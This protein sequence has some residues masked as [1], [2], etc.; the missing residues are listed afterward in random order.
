MQR[1]SSVVAPD[2]HEVDQEPTTTIYDND[3]H[4][5][6]VE[7]EVDK[8]GWNGKDA[9]EAADESEA[10]CDDKD[11]I[12]VVPSLAGLPLAG[13][14][15][16]HKASQ[17]IG[18]QVETIGVGEG[19]SLRRSTRKRKRIDPAPPIVPVVSNQSIRPPKRA[20]P[21]TSVPVKGKAT[22]AA[23]TD[24]R[25]SCPHWPGRIFQRYHNCLR[26][27]DT[28]KQCLGWNG[29]VYPCHRCGSEYTRRDAVKRHMD[30]KPNCA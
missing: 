7:D 16:L 11:P 18:H 2:L 1:V 24:G 10:R 22:A 20:R 26:H 8:S 14:T 23:T 17:E 27:M 4:E 12:D 25:Y 15:A 6:S 3:I 29:V 9:A 28:S 13:S 21:P 5:T 19:H 30:D